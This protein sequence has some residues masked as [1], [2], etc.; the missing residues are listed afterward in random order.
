M[1][2]IFM[3]LGVL[4]PLGAVAETRTTTVQVTVRKRA[5]EKAA[6]VVI[7][8]AGTAVEVVREDGRWVVVRVKGGEGYVPRTTLTAP[9]S[10]PTSAPVWSAPRRA[11]GALD[12]SLHVLVTAATASLR[13]VPEAGGGAAVTSLSRGARL[14]VLDASTRPGWL[15]VRD[16]TGR[17]G[18]IARGDVGDGAG[19]IADVPA[20]VAPEAPRERAR[21]PG[22]LSLRLDAGV[23]YRSLGMDM[24]SSSDGA[25]A[26]YLVDADAFAVSFAAD[27]VISP[28]GAW[29]AG[30]DAVV[31]TCRASPGIEYPGPSAAAG[32]IPFDTVAA[33]LGLR[34]GRRFGRGTVELALR[35]G[36][37]YDAF[38]A[39]D[40][41]NAGM[42]PRER[43]LG[44][45]AG[46]RAELRPAGS[47]FGATLRADVLVAGGRAQT[48][49]LE[50]GTSS[51]ARAVWGGVTIRAAVGARW[52]LFGAYDFARLSTEWSGMST[53]LPGVT[54]AERID[55]SQVVQL[56]LGAEL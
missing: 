42:L 50:D 26:N 2:R 54:R 23:G 35:A 40:V 45:T 7:V 53:R 9:P 37:H 8:P 32:E 19:A 3:L 5:G 16:E 11:G 34:G 18:W 6:A 46:G 22:Q 41:D 14:A 44:A 25:L 28:A 56:G 17:E 12:A 20:R 36:L 29:I 30:A 21:P 38:L 4:V 15:R 24:T 49:G 33:E 47:R 55:T 27:A 13:A 10:A 39:R 52:S 31:L 48:R 51:N 1:R 43:L